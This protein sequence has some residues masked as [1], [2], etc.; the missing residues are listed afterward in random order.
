VSPFSGVVTPAVDVAPVAVAASGVFTWTWLLVALPL[1]GAAILLL[2]GK[3]SN[4]WGHW[5]GVLAS[6]GSFVVGCVLFAAM[7]GQPDDARGAT[8][9]L[10]DWIQVGTFTAPVDLRLDQLSMTFVLLIT[11]VGTLFQ[12]L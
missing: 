5:V 2:A 11:G 12:I 9:H 4:A 7:L 1:A 10:F 6:L 8:Q 3:R